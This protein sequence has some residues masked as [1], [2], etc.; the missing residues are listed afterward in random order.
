MTKFKN[1]K[2]KKNNQRG[3]S[4]IEV[5][6]ATFVF[7]IILVIVSTNFVDIMKLQRRGFSAQVIQEEVLFA[8]ESMA[9]EIRVSQIQSPDDINCSLTSLT[10]L[11]PVSGSITYSINN[12]VLSKTADGT[13][14]S[15]T[16]TKINLARFNFCIRGSGVDGEQP[17]VTIIASVQTANNQEG[18]KIDLQTTISSRDM[19]EEF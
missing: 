18:L 8:V 13:T 12:G 15:V 19:S 7:S 9:R 3:F 4:I 16:S 6:V 14:Y 1:L 17:R 11:H 10:M 5:L 2:I